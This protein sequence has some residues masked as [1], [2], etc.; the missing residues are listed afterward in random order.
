M[1]FSRTQDTS[2]CMGLASTHIYLPGDHVGHQP[3][4]VFL[5]EFDLAA[6]ASCGSIEFGG[7]SVYEVCYHLLFFGRRP[8]DIDVADRVRVQIELGTKLSQPCERAFC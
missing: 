8:A 4:T 7:G 5:H 1:S 3:G 6:G 2:W